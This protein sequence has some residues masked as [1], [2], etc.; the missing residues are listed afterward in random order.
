MKIEEIVSIKKFSSSVILAME[1]LENV[2]VIKHCLTLSVG[3]I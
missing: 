1:T 2:A 3:K